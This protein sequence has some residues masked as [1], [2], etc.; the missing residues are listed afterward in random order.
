MQTAGIPSWRAATHARTFGAGRVGDHQQIRLH[1]AQDALH[2]A[3]RQEGLARQLRVPALRLGG[4]HLGLQFG[5]AQAHVGLAFGGIVQRA[6]RRDEFAAAG[7]RGFVARAD[8]I[9]EL[10]QGQA[11]GAH[12]RRCRREAEHLHLRQPGVPQGLCNGHHHADMAGTVAD[13]QDLLHGWGPACAC[14]DHRASAASARSS[15]VWLAVPSR[16]ADSM[17]SMASGRNS[18]RSSSLPCSVCCSHG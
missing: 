15:R 18:R 5:I 16:C 2:R 13:E 10:Q 9:L 3:H 12:H 4:A 8:E 17:A 6:H 7:Q 11:R 14:A 1:L